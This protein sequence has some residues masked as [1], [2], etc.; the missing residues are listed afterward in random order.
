MSI[1]VRRAGRLYQIVLYS[2]ILISGSCLL[3]LDEA[4]P[5]DI[6]FAMA[7]CF[8]YVRIAI[9]DLEVRLIPNRFLIQLIGLQFLRVIAEIFRKTEWT[10]LLGDSLAAA[11]LFCVA[12]FIVRRFTGVK[13]LVIG[14]GDLKYLIVLALCL[15]MNGSMIALIVD[16]LVLPIIWLLRNRMFRDTTTIPGA[17]IWS[18]GGSVAMMFSIA[19]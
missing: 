11:L 3:L 6:L 17:I 5:M 9:H 13:V 18:A 4:D 10:L 12:V 15:G 16:L 1:S 7:I 19:D 8:L 14:D 2:Y